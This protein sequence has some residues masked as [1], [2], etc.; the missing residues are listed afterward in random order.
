MSSEQGVRP[1][2]CAVRRSFRAFGVIPP[3]PEIP[4]IPLDLAITDLV[5][6]TGTQ[7]GTVRLEFT[8]PGTTGD[9]APDAYRVR[10][11]VRHITP[12]DQAGS[13]IVPVSASP[14]TVGSAESITVGGLSPGRTLQFTVQTVRGSTAGPMGC[15][16]GGR[17]AG[18]DVPA[19]P[20]NAILLTGPATLSQSGATYVLTRDVTTSGTAFR[21]TAPGITFDLGGHRVV[22]GIDSITKYGITRKADGMRE[23]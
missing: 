11:S 4:P 23:S 16:A 15:G 2:E 14:G 3:V 20:S 19:A 21:I 22:Y 13:V 7:P 8:A 5:V 9:P 1:S 6:K 10:S 17:V 18:R 12:S